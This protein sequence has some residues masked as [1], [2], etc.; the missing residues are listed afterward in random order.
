MP[1]SPLPDELRSFLEKPNPAVIATL[2]P[3]GQPVTVATWYVLDGDRIYVNM[4][5]G[6][7]R[8]EHLRQD[9]RVS[10]TVLGDES[11]YQHVSFVGRVVE[12]AGDP[13]LSGIDRLSTHYTG[14]P[15]SNRDN[16]RVGAWIEI[17]RWHTWT[18]GRPMKVEL[19]ARG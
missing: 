9:P 15:Y 14:N 6:R 17:E 8:V 13:D 19:E 2:R 1:S 16:E 12:M 5:A 7:K 10:L 4:D 18:S 3:D 11:W